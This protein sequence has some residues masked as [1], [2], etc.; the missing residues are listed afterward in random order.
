VEHKEQLDILTELGCDEVQGYF[1]SRPVP[2]DIFEQRF[3]CNEQ[4]P[5]LT[6]A[7]HPIE[8]R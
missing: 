6:V 8:V 3:L 1:F 4:S 7:Q 2:P 5:E